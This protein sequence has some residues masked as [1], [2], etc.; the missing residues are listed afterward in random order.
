MPIIIVSRFQRMG[1][2]IV[3]IIGD[4]TAN[5]GDPSGRSSERPPLTDEDIARNLSGYP[6]QGTPFIEFGRADL[7]F[8]G[9]WLNNVTLPELVGALARVPVSMSGL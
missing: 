5:I 7:R 2:H 1:H 6:R 4:V 3:F 8:N 9:E